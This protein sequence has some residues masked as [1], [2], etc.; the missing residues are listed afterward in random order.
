MSSS[1]TISI[2]TISPAPDD[3]TTRL[4]EGIHELTIVR[5][6]LKLQ[7]NRFGDKYAALHLTYAA[8]NGLTASS[9]TPEFKGGIVGALTAL[10]EFVLNLRDLTPE[11]LM[12]L[13]GRRVRATI[14]HRAYRNAIYANV[15]A[16]EG[17]SL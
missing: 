9:M 13:R 7:R 6:D 10:E 14:S 11:R 4:P 3:R 1:P 17:R 12:G 2:I 8:D 16:L 5:A 15:T